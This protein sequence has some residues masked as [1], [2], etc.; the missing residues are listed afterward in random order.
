MAPAAQRLYQPNIK[1]GDRRRKET[2]MR[3]AIAEMD[4][5]I[6]FGLMTPAELRRVIARLEDVR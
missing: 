5:L 6:E 4:I 3:E 2:T 1:G